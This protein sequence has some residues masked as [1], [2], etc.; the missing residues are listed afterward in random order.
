VIVRLMGGGG[1]YRVDDDLMAKLDELDTA[2]L[3]ALE[4]ADETE[5]DARL[6]EMAELVRASGEALP[7]EDLSASDVVIP[8]SDLTLEETRRL[9]SEDGLIPDLPAA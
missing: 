4:R 7:E 5:L 9:F 1:Q 3:A 2:A 6:D 8:P